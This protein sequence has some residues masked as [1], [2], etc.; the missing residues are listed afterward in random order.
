MDLGQDTTFCQLVS[1]RKRLKTGKA[2]KEERQFAHEHPEIIDVPEIDDRSLQEKE[3]EQEFLRKVE[4]ARK[5]NA[6]G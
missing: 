2:T 3:I 6:N 5:R 4:E 1:L